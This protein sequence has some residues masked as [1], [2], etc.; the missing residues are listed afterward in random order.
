[1]T[2]RLTFA[3]FVALVLSA[4]ALARATSPV[5]VEPVYYRADLLER[6]NFYDGEGR[7]VFTQAI[8]WDD[9]GSR[10]AVRDWRILKDSDSVCEVNGIFRMAFMA[11]DG[12]VFVV[13]ADTYAETWTQFDPE[14][15]DRDVLPD[16][17]RRKI[18]RE[19]PLLPGRRP[20]P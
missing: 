6:N 9:Y 8:W 19:T 10:Y 5:L 17:W 3:L 12:H 4:V 20:K 1:M 15:L 14:V 7:L 13:D 18:G 2:S 11:N 16:C